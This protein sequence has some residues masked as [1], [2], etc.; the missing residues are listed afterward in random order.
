MPL[1]MQ[2]LDASLDAQ[3]CIVDAFIVV[4]SCL[5]KHSASALSQS[6]RQWSRTLRFVAWD[7]SADAVMRVIW[8]I[9]VF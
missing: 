4:S 1:D 9:P 7:G 8:R 3:R 6:H 5:H 2:Q